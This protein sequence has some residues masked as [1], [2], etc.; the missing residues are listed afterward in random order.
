MTRRGLEN[1]IDMIDIKWLIYEFVIK[2]ISSNY[3]FKPLY[4]FQCYYL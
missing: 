1:K 4:S 3:K 2:I